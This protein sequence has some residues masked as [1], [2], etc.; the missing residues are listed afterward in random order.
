MKHTNKKG[1]TI[2]E[3]VI[4]IAVIAILA[5]VLIP[6]FAGIIRKANLS[7]DQQLVAQMNNVLY[8]EEALGGKPTHVIGAKE[9]LSANGL[10]DFS[11]N[12]ENNV[13]YWIGTDNRVVLWER[14]EDNPATGKVTYPKDLAKEYKSLTTP[15]DDWSD[16]SLDYNFTEVEVAEGETLRSALLDVVE[17]AE[18]GA[19]I[20]LPKGATVDLG[21]GGMY[22]LGSYMKN[23]GGT[24]KSLTIDLNGGSIES[25]TPHSNGY[26]YGGEV[27]AGGSLTIVNGSIDMAGYVNG[28][29]VES[30]AHLI[31]RDVELNVPDGDA[32]FPAGDA[33]EIILENC[34]I[35]AGANYGIAT[36]NQQSNNIYIKI[37]NT[38]IQAPSCAILVNVPCDALI[39]NSTIIG[40]GWGVFVRSGHVAINNTTIRTT[41]GDVGANDSRYNTSCEYF[42]YNQTTSNIPYWG[43][44]PQVPYAPLIVGDYS[45]HDSYNHDTTCTLTNVVFDNADSSKIPDVVIAAGPSGK[46]VVLNYDN[47][48]KVARLVVYGDGYARTEVEGVAINHTFEHKGTI[49]VNGVAKGLGE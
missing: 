15:S 31:M 16:L 42:A 5:A 9:I 41:D 12:D 21:A 27:P 46:D 36:N 28:F 8:A 7:I 48:T 24:G 45:S 22:F 49:T 37:S 43:Q 26:Y 17:A 25:N 10:D 32:I 40:G 44:G 18:D 23:A 33:S 1:F 30:G 29:D 2:V 13:F 19:I 6:T 11:P 39:D 38:T 20:K 34:K 3:L 4:V 14:N 47:A 35:V